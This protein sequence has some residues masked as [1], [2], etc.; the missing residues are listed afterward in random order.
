MLSPHKFRLLT[1][2]ALLALTL[3]QGAFAQV[4]GVPTFAGTTW[5]SSPEA[6]IA[7]LTS[8]GYTTTATAPNERNAISFDGRLLNQDAL[9]LAWFD[10]QNQLVKT[11]VYILTK[12]GRGEE[13]PTAKTNYENLKAILTN[14][15]GEP[16]DTFQFFSSPYEEGDGYED[17]A[18]AVN[19]GHYASFW[20][21]YENGSLSLTI[22]TDVD[23][24]LAYETKEWGKYLDEKEEEG[25]ENF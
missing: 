19:K 14:R 20:T 18:F 10:N 5:L 15:Y 22:D 13:F 6:V 25:S 8:E 21:D 11:S 4:D 16:T 1:A 2:T 7:Q 23:V 3:L 12:V 17:T 9:V 24:A